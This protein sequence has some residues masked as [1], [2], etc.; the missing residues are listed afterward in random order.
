MK[1]IPVRRGLV[2]FSLALLLRLGYCLSIDKT[3]LSPDSSDWESS[4]FSLLDEGRFN[5][6]YRGPATTVF[7]AGIHLAFGRDVVPVRIVQALLGSVTCLLIFSIGTMIFFEEAGFI[8]AVIA[9]LYPYFIYFTGDIMSET[10]LIFLIA[11]YI[12]LY[13][14]SLGSG[15]KSTSIL[16]G[17]AGGAALLCKGTFLPFFG[18]SLAWIVIAMEGSLIRRAKIT[19]LIGLSAAA[20][21]APWTARNFAKY[22]KFVLLGLGGQSLWLAN[23][24]E[25]YKLETLPET[26]QDRLDPAFT[27]YDAEKMKEIS[28]LPP[29]AADLRFREEAVSYIKADP[30]RTAA[31]ALKRFVHFWRLYPIV[32]TTRNK[33]IALMTSGIILPLGW[34]G[35]I[36]SLRRYWRR[37]FVLMLLPL[38]FSAVHMVFLANIRYR[39]P[40]DP[41]MIIFAAFA[42]C[43]LSPRLSGFRERRV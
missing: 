33:I 15:K 20:V 17:I 1:A 14:A 26:D 9:A 28:G 11:L 13:Y 27:W 42:L 41:Y 36:L 23:N 38:S 10:L 21:V 12:T 6:D 29:L 40:C 4:A 30:G 25:A 16:C 32:A 19:L 37:S 43:A 7:L 24:P 39:I 8:A 2:V 3:Y 34:A 35:M 31:L 18:L 22:D 5:S